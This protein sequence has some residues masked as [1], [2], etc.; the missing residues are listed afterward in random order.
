[1]TNSVFLCLGTNLG[2]RLQNI[3][4][5]EVHIAEF[6][7]EICKSSSLYESEPWGNVMQAFFLNEVLHVK[8]M[9]S[10]LDL[11]EA[12]QKIEKKL[13]LAKKE[14]WG[15]RTMDIDILFYNDLIIH[16]PKL[17]IPHPHL[18]K[19]N[20]VLKPLAEIAREMFHPLLQEK[21]NKLY[22][23]SEDQ[24][25]VDLYKIQKEVLEL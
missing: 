17:I 11:L 4:N 20:F 13:N 1:M 24:S 10:P 7:G 25:L 14:L 15:P 21:I 8:T 22:Q 6:I 18:H 2:K 5:A 23:K 16:L 3:R 9:L 19:R 12:T